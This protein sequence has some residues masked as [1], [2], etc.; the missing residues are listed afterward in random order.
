[1]TAAIVD[2]AGPPEASKLVISG[3]GKDHVLVTTKAMCLEG[4][5][6]AQL[7]TGKKNTV[8]FRCETW[9]KPHENILADE[10]LIRWQSDKDFPTIYRH[11]RGARFA[12][13]PRWAGHRQWYPEQEVGDNDTTE[14]CCNWEDEGL[15]YEVTSARYCKGSDDHHGVCVDAAKCK[16]SDS[17]E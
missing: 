9:D 15:G 11:W 12:R 4:E 13:D 17:E 10:W 2:D 7:V 1:M 3:D 5:H 16:A 8:L 6:A 14:C